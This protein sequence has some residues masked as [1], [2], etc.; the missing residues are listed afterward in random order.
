MNQVKQTFFK[1]IFLS[2]LLSACGSEESQEKVYEDIT[3][4]WEYSSPSF[5][6]E[7]TIVKGLDESYN[8]EAGATYA[9][10]GGGTYT[11][12]FSTEL[13]ISGLY[14]E[15]WIF[16]S[17]DV[18]DYA[19]YLQDIEYASDYKTMTSSTQT[20]VGE[21]PNETYYENVEITRK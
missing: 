12:A 7:F 10:T 3:G 14:I 20:V 4:D 5:S 18:G 15:P 19:I 17:N 2:T 9:F 16:L 6:G 8:V 11:S 13:T 21:N 1:I